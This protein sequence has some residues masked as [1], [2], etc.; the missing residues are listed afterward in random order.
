MRQEGG[1]GGRFDVA[2]LA[3]TLPETAATSLADRYITDRPSG[4][5][6]VFHA[7]RPM[8]PHVR[9]ECDE[10]LYVLPG[11]GVLWMGDLS[12]AAP[13]GPGQSL[14]F[15]RDTVHAMPEVHEHPVVFLAIDTPRRAPDDVVFVDPAAGDAG[16]F[17]A[18]NAAGRDPG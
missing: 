9:R 7:D 18:R 12:A 3:A 17:M 2:A 5:A 13:F 10:D 14:V 1:I 8:P 15:D 11:R 16:T 4:S 6:R